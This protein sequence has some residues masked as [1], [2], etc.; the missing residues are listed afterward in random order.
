VST[1]GAAFDGGVA[2]TATGGCVAN[3]ALAGDGHVGF[4]G[5][6]HLYGSSGVTG[7]VVAV[8]RDFPPVCPDQ[9]IDVTRDTSFAFA[10]HCSD[11]NGDAMTYSVTAAPGKANLG[12]IDQ[13]AGL[14][15]YNPFGGYVGGDSFTFRAF[16]SPQSSNVATATVNVVAPADPPPA[17]QPNPTGIDADKDGFF[18]GQDCNDGNAAIRPGATEIRGN[19]IDENCDAFAEPFPTITSG[20]ASKWDVK[21]T[22]LTLTSL[23]VTQQFP[24]GWKAVIKCSGKPKCSFRSKTLKAG[25]V[26]KGAATIISSL[27]KKQRRFRAGQTIEVWI[28]APDF[29]TK[30]ARLVLKKGKIPTTQPFCVLPGQTKPQKSCN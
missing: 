4:A 17:P 23:Q 7:A 29:N 20:V 27:S 9:A 18:A 6:N 26:S 11:R 24:K 3:A 12:A 22:R 8:K 19:N 25:K 15:F 28:S 30:V 5:A 10:F 16:A 21:G 13:A 1:T 2:T 14:V